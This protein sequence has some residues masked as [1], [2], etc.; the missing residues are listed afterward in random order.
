GHGDRDGHRNRQERNPE[1]H[2][3]AL[4]TEI[5]GEESHRKQ[6]GAGIAHG[7]A[8]PCASA[9][10]RRGSADV[11]KVLPAASRPG[12]DGR[13]TTCDPGAVVPPGLTGSPSNRRYRS[14]ATPLEG[15]RG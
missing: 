2:A 4:R 7:D 5:G 14:A 1:T 8:G 15:K 9:R 13:F 10:G 11:F 3:S 12:R 6:S